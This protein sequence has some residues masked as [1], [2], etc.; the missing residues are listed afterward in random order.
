MRALVQRVRQAE[1]TVDGETVGAIGPG[2]LVLVGAVDTDTPRDV[3]VLAEKLLSMR[4]FSDTEGKMNVSVV[5]T[6]GSVLVVSQFTLVGDITKGRRPSFTS[7]ARPAHAKALIDD[8]VRSID[9]KGTRVAS[10]RFGARMDVS[11]VNAGP[12]TFLVDVADGRV[13]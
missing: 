4:I 7:A 2:M 12:V 11:L 1:V 10:G 13:V 3:A 5:D 8:L 6:G 9:E